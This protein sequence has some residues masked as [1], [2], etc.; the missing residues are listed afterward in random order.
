MQFNPSMALKVNNMQLTDVGHASI[1]LTLDT[2]SQ[3]FKQSLH[4]STLTTY[5][6]ELVFKTF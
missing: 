1:T 2:Y 3:I 6:G 5:Q 4:Y